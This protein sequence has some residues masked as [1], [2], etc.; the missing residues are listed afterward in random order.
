MKRRNQKPKLK[1]KAVMKFIGK[2]KATTINQKRLLFF[3]LGFAV[4]GTFFLVKS[5]A[6]DDTT[7]PRKP[8][9]VHSSWVDTDPS[10]TTNYVCT[11]AS[12]CTPTTLV[13]YWDPSSD[14]V[15]VDH[16][17]ILVANAQGQNLTVVGQVPRSAKPTYRVANLDPKLPFDAYIQAVDASGNKSPMSEL[18][19]N[20]FTTADLIA[21]SQPG[22]V[23]AVFN[24]VNKTTTVSWTPSADN[25]KS[26]STLK[27][28]DH[29]NIFYSSC[30]TTDVGRIGM[31]DGNTTTFQDTR[32]PTNTRVTY[33]V[34]AADASITQNFSS[35]GVADVFTDITPPST[36]NNLAVVPNTVYANT[37]KLHFTPPTDN[38]SVKQID[39][40][41]NGVKVDTLP[42]NAS[43]FVD[44][45]LN[46]GTLYSYYLRVIDTAGNTST[47]NTISQSTSPVATNT[48]DQKVPTIS[49]TSPIYESSQP[50]LVKGN[51]QLVAAK[52]SD[53]V[54]ITKVE[55]LIDNA[56]K[57][58]V[59]IPTANSTYKYIWDTTASVN[60]VPVYSEGWHY[61][62]ARAY[63]AAGNVTATTI[64]VTVANQDK[65]PPATP[66]NL[67]VMQGSRDGMLTLSWNPAS[68]TQDQTLKGYEVYSA[69]KN[70]K[71]GGL[72]APDASST[73]QQD[74]QA[75]TK[76]TYYI[77]A[78]DTSNNFSPA[79][80]SASAITMYATVNI[81]GDVEAYG[82]IRGKITDVYGKA[83]PSA[84][85]KLNV[86]D[87][88]DVTRTN[89]LGDYD[90]VDGLR[91][92][93]TMVVS[94]T[95]YVTQSTK[96]TIYKGQ[97]VYQ[98]MTLLKP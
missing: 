28:I 80:N 21:P 79:S 82:L 87:K 78:F 89:A 51:N 62:G 72:D 29:Y 36:I 49:L 2:L 46:T 37:L 93:Y 44:D 85:V 43:E 66:L 56:V 32:M 53:N 73:Y 25:Y 55:F 74:L 81:T 70:T 30:S 11:P 92:T 5:F 40:Y 18:A 76:Y 14:N 98:N 61:L 75:L 17:D 68:T 91:G 86:R 69:G 54:G 13:L 64:R 20:T 88:P 8:K 45:K 48:K 41:R 1:S 31:V 15:G 52:A 9:N 97:T 59:T 27:M 57:Q 19:A 23:K 83:I 71:V 26:A 4:V 6:L 34:A 16:Y 7:P 84:L 95:G 10:N 94:A 50:T 38:Y 67:S 65:T 90:I 77:R 47:S 58:T 39:V 42:S 3:M 60:G 12:D 33:L 63:D 22:D 96:I 35:C 24:P